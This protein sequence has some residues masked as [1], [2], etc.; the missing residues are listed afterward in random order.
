MICLKR[1]K[2]FQKPLG[3]F[4]GCFVLYYSTRVYLLDFPL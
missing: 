3:G 4:K 1:W 2:D